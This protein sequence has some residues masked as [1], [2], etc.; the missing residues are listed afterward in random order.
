MQQ[1]ASQQ[2]TPTAQRRPALNILMS[3]NAIEF[4]EHEKGP[5]WYLTFAIIAA[6][7]VLYELFIKDFFGAITLA[8]IAVIVYFFSRL[9]PKDVLV[10]ITDKGM[11]LN[12]T[13]VPY[14]NVKHFWFVEQHASPMLHIETN[15]YINQYIVV[16]LHDQSIEQV[17][18]TLL[19]YIGEIGFDQEPVSHR[20][21]RFFKF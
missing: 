16:H 9:K 15:A 14:S 13:F 20:V 5:G 21:A 4:E 3:W 6:L 12:D 8:I 19:P 11:M 1:E 7:F 10:Q 2:T 17:R 18:E